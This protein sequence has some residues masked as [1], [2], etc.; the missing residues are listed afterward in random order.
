M[1]KR[2]LIEHQPLFLIIL[3]F[4]IGISLVSG[5][6][7]TLNCQVTTNCITTTVFKISS[8]TNAHSE[9]PSLSNY[10]YKVCCQTEIYELNNSC[11]TGYNVLKLSGTTNAHVEK[12]TYANY[13][14]KVC[15]SFPGGNI[16]C[17]YTTQ[18]CDVEGYDTCLATISGDTNA[19][20]G[21]CISSPY[22]TKICCKSGC[23]GSVSGTVRNQ[24]NQ[25]IT[26]AEV[27]L[28]KGLTTTKSTTTNQLGIYNLTS[29]SCGTYNLVAS[30]H[31]YITQTIGNVNISQQ[32]TVNFEVENSLV[33]GTSCEQD[34][35][36]AAGDIIHA[37]CEG[38]N[39]CTFYDSIAKSVCDNSQP[40]WVRDYN[41]THYV[42]CASGS[43]QP[44]IEIKASVSCASGTLVKITRIV[45][46]NGK[47][48]NLVV[49]VCG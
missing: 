18:N 15:L 41:A 33:L 28:K 29:V 20:V 10:A 9:I 48:V 25:S 2:S 35:T 24:D 27:T 44:K 22:Q 17:I 30:H 40:G 26:S 12:N 38:K 23:A 8:L 13:Q 43:P 1:K 21:D 46:Y 11:E 47:P 3:I 36:F 31:D 45:V 6:A 34:C 32:T 14:T 5:D 7:S 19:H 16:S 37:S 39:G 42:I 49:A 4:L